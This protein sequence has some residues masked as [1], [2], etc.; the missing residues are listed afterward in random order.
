M[1]ALLLCLIDVGPR[2]YHVLW[3]E[4]V[5]QDDLVQLDAK[6]VLIDH[7]PK[8]FLHFELKLLAAGGQDFIDR[9]ITDHLTHDCLVHCAE[10]DNRIPNPEQKIVSIVDEVLRGPL[11]VSHVQ[12]A[13]DDERGA[14]ALARCV[15][16][17]SLWPDLDRGEPEF[18]LAYGRHL[19]EVHLV[20]PERQFKLQPLVRHDVAV[21]FAQ[22]QHHGVLL[23]VDFV[24]TRQ[25]RHRDQYHA[26]TAKNHLV[27][28]LRV[29]PNF[30][31]KIS[32]RSNAVVCWR[33]G[34][35]ARLTALAAKNPRGAQP[36]EEDGEGADDGD[37][38]GVKRAAEP[39][40]FSFHVRR[41]CHPQDHQH[42]DCRA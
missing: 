34:T 33:G 32:H 42:A 20:D 19:N 39:A 24:K 2:G 28:C 12:V 7:H 36:H 27:Q 41:E 4:Y 11:D 10:C 6:L 25:D 3:W 14:S 18:L 17:A 37:H 8:L 13:G 40:K 30:V 26:D 1:F 23:R 15:A 9:A 5:L 29:D 35:V 22:P 21:D 16:G 31:W 38:V